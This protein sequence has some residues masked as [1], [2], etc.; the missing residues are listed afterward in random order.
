VDDTKRRML[1]GTPYVTNGLRAG[2]NTGVVAKLGKERNEHRPM[3][4]A[5]S[6]A[7][8]SMVAARGRGCHMKVLVAYEESYRSY[9]QLIT[10]AIREMRPGLEVHSAGIGALGE[11]LGRFEPHVVICS[12]SS[13]DYPGGRAAWVEIPV[14]P[15][16]PSHVCLDG[17]HEETVNP[18]LAKVLS[19]LDE[20]EQRLRRGALAHNC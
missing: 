10:K 14:E 13:S 4:C 12:R 8:S 5:S 3:P 2:N 11:E 20:T 18:G 1:I 19:V 15:A 7:A 6:L 16:R 9:G 17:D